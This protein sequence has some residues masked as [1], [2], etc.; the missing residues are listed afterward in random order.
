MEDHDQATIPVSDHRLRTRLDIQDFTRG[1]D[2]LSA[3]GGGHPDALGIRSLLEEDL[4]SGRLLS[5]VDL[6][7]LPDDAR[8]V[9][10]VF[11]GSIAPQSFGPAALEKRMGL[12]RKVER[13]LIF[14]VR[15]LE[16]F[17]ARSFDFVISSEIGGVNTAAALD[18][19]ANLGLPLVDADYAGRAIP[20]STCSTPSLHGKPVYPMVLV[21][22]YGDTTYVKDVQNNRMAERLV[23]HIAAGSLGLVGCARLSLGGRE[24]KEIAVPGTLSECLRIGRT[25]REARESG[26]DPVQEAVNELG[27]AWILFRGS[28][29][30]REWEDRQG[31]M[32]GEHEI[33][34]ADDFAGHSL[35][36][37]FKNEN[38]M[39]WLD[40]HPYA[41]SPDI[42]ELVDPRTAEP[43]SNT[44][45]ECG[46]QVVLIGVRRRVQF[47]NARGL[48][49]LGP[50]HWGFDVDFR[51]IELL[52]R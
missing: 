47:D 42:L 4:Q 34:G 11:S 29:V 38:H 46:R 28:I 20:E 35:R 33:E 45:L 2:F 51:P 36:L 22:F 1:T 12:E 21:D 15:E 24:V 13:P 40:G 31:Y 5:W 44:Y 9:C 19:A 41:A 18:T 25:I 52:V 23:K 17:T 48:E 10:P 37:W 43:L 14:A 39:S 6:G 50:R 8:V 26:R 16:A 3:N 49:A 32:W 7:E 27:Q 30:S